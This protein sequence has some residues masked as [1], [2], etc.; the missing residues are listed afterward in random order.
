[1]DLNMIIDLVPPSLALDI[2]RACVCGWLPVWNVATL[3][4]IVV[5]R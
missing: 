4:C 1:M 2:D 3:G 5:D